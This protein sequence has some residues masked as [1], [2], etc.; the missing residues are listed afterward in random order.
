LRILL[1]HKAE[2]KLEGSLLLRILCDNIKNLILPKKIQF[3]LIQLGVEM[4]E[5]IFLKI[6]DFNRISF[7]PSFIEV[8]KIRKKFRYNLI[9][10]LD[11]SLY[12]FFCYWILYSDRKIKISRNTF[13]NINDADVSERETK[14]AESVLNQINDDNFYQ[15]KLP[16]LNVE[17][18]KLLNTKKIINWILESSGQKK[19][20]FLN[21]I[22]IY[23]RINNPISDIKKVNNLIEE[24]LRNTNHKIILTIDNS[25]KKIIKLV[26]KKTKINKNIILNFLA[27]NDIYYSIKFCQK[28][29]TTITNIGY[30]SVICDVIG[31]N[32][33]F[34][35]TTKLTNKNISFISEQINYY[36]EKGI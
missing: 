10:N 25:E 4:N 24:I 6:N 31:C 33:I 36:S 8:W 1:I 7:A 15:I 27:S 22:F 13:K 5:N 11:K 12:S 21:F 19:L 2:S 20:E 23:F 16:S 26:K 30:M 34:P 35:K 17:K 28:S 32:Y 9:I 18:I 29:K 3:D 14:A